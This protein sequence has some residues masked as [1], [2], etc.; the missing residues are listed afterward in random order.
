M[1]ARAW[2]GAREGLVIARIGIVE[3]EAPPGGGGQLVGSDPSRG[4]EQTGIHE[5]EREQDAEQPLSGRRLRPSHGAA[6]RPAV[7]ALS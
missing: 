2:G 5:E 7:A 4:S 6:A 3:D 1:L